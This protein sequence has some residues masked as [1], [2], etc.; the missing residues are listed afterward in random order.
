MP[1]ISSKERIASLRE[2]YAVIYPSLRLLEGEFNVSRIREH[3]SSCSS[4]I[5]SRKRLEKFIDEDQE[6]GDDECDICM[7]K[8]RKMVLPNCVHSLCISCFHDWYLRSESCPFCRGSL[9]RV[10]STDLWEVIGDSDVI[11]RATLAMDN[12]RRFYLFMETL[13]LNI[14]E[15]HVYAFNYML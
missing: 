3:R 12:I 2:F 11:D 7:E 9:K 15:A 5:V 10:S 6:G 8:S 14:P 1:S 13:P 4:Q